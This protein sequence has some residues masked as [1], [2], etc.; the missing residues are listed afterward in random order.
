MSH[1]TN[2]PTPNAFA[3]ASPHEDAGPPPSTN[4]AGGD[5]KGNPKDALDHARPTGYAPPRVRPMGTLPQ[6]TGMAMS[7]FELGQPP[8]RP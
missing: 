7:V 3:A 8:T 4:G 5:P 1:P 6:A 2:D